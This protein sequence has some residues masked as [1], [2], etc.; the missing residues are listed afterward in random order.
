MNSMPNQKDL[1]TETLISSLVCRVISLSDQ[2]KRREDSS[3]QF[4]KLNL[5]WEFLDA[6][7]GRLMKAFPKEYD[8]RKRVR[9]YGFSMSMG[10]ICCF[11]S[12]RKAWAECV[13]LGKTMLVLE[14]D[15]YFKEGVSQALSIV[16]ARCDWDLFRLH[17]AKIYDICNI[18]HLDDFIVYDNLVDPSCTTA[19]LITPS[20]AEKLLNH[21]NHFFKAVDCY[22]EDRWAHKANIKSIFPFPVGVGGHITTISDRA[23]EKRKLPVWR[24][25]TKELCRTYAGFRRFLYRQYLKLQ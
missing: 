9:H 21:S 8:N 25:V 5:N 7:D 2:K 10:E 16:L 22:M 17:G 14:D 20:G 4:S 19:Y 6:V 11:L 24:K 15:F 12:H 13:K 3:K 1:D 18:E 23:S